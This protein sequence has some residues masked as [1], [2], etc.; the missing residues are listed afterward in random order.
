M[1]IVFQVCDGKHFRLIL[2]QNKSIEFKYHL[3][4]IL[5]FGRFQFGYQTSLTFNLSV[6]GGNIIVPETQANFS[7]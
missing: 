6:H 7:K 4:K 3:L 2:I 5:C 1:N